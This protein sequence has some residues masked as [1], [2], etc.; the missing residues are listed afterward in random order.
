[1][2]KYRI[3]DRKV[4]DFFLPNFKGTNEANPKTSILRKQRATNFP[5]GKEAKSKEQRAKSKITSDVR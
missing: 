3:L 1:M 4:G 5:A 2:V